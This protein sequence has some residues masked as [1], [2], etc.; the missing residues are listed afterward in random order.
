MGEWRQIEIKGCLYLCEEVG[1]KFVVAAERLALRVHQVV[2]RF[3]EPN[4]VARHGLQEEARLT[5]EKLKGIER[6]N[7]NGKRKNKYK[8]RQIFQRWKNNMCNQFK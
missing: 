3:D 7:D 2:L 4:E 8:M 5:V 1:H 6:G